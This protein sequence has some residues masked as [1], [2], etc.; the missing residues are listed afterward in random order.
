MRLWHY[1]LIKKLPRQQLLGQHR[2]CCALRGKGWG[3]PHATVNYVFKYSRGDLCRYHVLVMAEMAR[4]GYRVAQEW[5]DLRYR[6]KALEPDSRRALET[7]FQTY[8]EHNQAYLDE[9]LEN[10][11]RK[12]IEITME[13]DCV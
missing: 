13:E 3:K 9:C 4:R 2:E 10:L 5:Q 1:K 11:A 7:Y 8:P 12:G 6:G